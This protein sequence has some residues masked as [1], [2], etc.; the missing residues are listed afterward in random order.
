[1]EEIKLWQIN[2]NKIK[3]LFKNQLDFESRLEEWIL[4]DISIV[5]NEFMVIDSYVRTEFGKE[6]DILAIDTNGNL[7]I[8]ELK[9]DKT[10][11]D[12]VAQALEYAS[13]VKDLT[14]ND[15]ND[16]Y[17]E[18]N[19]NVSIEEAYNKHFNLDF[20][21]EINEDHRIVIVGSNIDD[22]TIRIIRY[23][24]DY[25][26]ININAMTFNYFKDIDG[27]EFLAKSSLIP[28]SELQVKT[29]KAQRQRKQSI[30]FLFSTNKLKIDDEVIFYPAIDNKIDKND[31][32]ISAKIINTSQKCLRRNNGDMTLYSFSKLRDIII[33]ECDLHNIKAGW[34]FELKNEWGLRD[35]RRLVDL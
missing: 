22:S 8:I 6:I 17:S 18:N 16:I 32:K 31:T 2:N 25:H 13:W 30:S 11:R 35:G 26:N 15:I 4:E 29:K 28:E 20:P 27:R 7:V 10:P 33:K 34:N 14:F 24:S 1:M 5:S 3:E 21:E 23:L 12:V 19:K 9:R